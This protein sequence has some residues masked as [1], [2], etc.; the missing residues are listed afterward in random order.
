MGSRIILV[1]YACVEKHRTSERTDRVTYESDDS[2]GSH[3]LLIYRLDHR[4]IQYT[5]ICIEIDTNFTMRSTKKAL[6]NASWRRGLSRSSLSNST[7]ETKCGGAAGCAVVVPQLA[8]RFSGKDH[9]KN[10]A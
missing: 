2:E 6:L 5:R 8:K 7:A 10:T 9:H 3:Y 4:N 1:W